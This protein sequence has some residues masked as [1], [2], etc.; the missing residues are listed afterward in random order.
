MK[1]FSLLMWIDHK[2]D[3]G[4]PLIVRNP[5]CAM[6]LDGRDR[7]GKTAAAA[8]AAAMQYLV[9]KVCFGLVLD[10]VD[11]LWKFICRVL[12]PDGLHV[13]P[14]VRAVLVACL[15][16]DVH[17]CHGVLDWKRRLRLKESL[18]LTNAGTMPVVPHTHRE[19]GVLACV[20]QRQGAKGRSLWRNTFP[21]LNEIA[22]L[23]G[24]RISSIRSTSCSALCNLV[25]VFCINRFPA[26]QHSIQGH[27]VLHQLEWGGT[28]AKMLRIDTL[29]AALI[30]LPLAFHPWNSRNLRQRII[31]RIV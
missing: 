29:E 19:S 12:E 25:A 31:L 16:D 17:H 10:K 7:R 21:P 13:R 11:E 1:S 30:L 6:R 23:P 24:S 14:L 18:A 5:P 9:H 15:L 28:C 20:L 22:R 26:R 3:S 27:C 4:F 8:A 2:R